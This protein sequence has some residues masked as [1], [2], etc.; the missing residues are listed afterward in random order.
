[1]AHC[2]LDLWLE[3]WVLRQECV[4]GL[5][6]VNRELIEVL[7]RRCC[8][9]AGS[10]QATG[11]CLQLAKLVD[12][13]THVLALVHHIHHLLQVS[14]L[15]SNCWLME[16]WL[17]HSSELLKFCLPERHVVDQDKVVTPV[18]REHH[19]V[20]IIKLLDCFVTCVLCDH[21]EVADAA[22]TS[23]RHTLLPCHGCS[24][25]CWEC[26]RKAQARAGRN[27]RRAGESTSCNEGHSSFRKLPKY[28]HFN[29][30]T[31]AQAA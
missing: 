5:G 11:T 28:Q 6:A 3:V 15:C 30:M 8:H 1:M 13:V 23:S 21:L 25:R 12:E 14:H 9:E 22:E 31:S 27:R 7:D 29:K 4:V 16:V 18:G 19:R 24:P 10:H 26:R 20:E 2:L 17:H